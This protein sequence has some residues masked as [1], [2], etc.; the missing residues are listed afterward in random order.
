MADPATPSV[1][2]P[3][4][5]E[6]TKPKVKPPSMYRVILVNDDFTPREFVVFVLVSIFRKDHSE[7]RQIMITAHQG[8]KSLVG[9]YTYDVATSRVDRARKQATEAGYPLMFY[10]EEV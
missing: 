3:Q 2:D 6:V 1:T 9:V 5:K 10:T 4:V 7:A 8:G